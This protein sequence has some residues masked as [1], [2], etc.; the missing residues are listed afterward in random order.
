MSRSLFLALL[1]CCAL[2]AQG[3]NALVSEVKFPWTVVR[4]NLLKM[5]EKMPAE[6]YSFK[7]TP[8]IES[9]G[10]RLAHI[11]GANLFV[12][13]GVTGTPNNPLSPG[14]EFQA[15]ADRVAEAGIHRLRFG[16][17]FA[18][19]CGGDGEDQ[20]PSRRT[21]SSR[22]DPNETC[23]PEQHGPT[24]ERGVRIHV[25]LSAI[26]RHRAAIERAGIGSPWIPK[27]RNR[28]PRRDRGQL[29]VHRG[30][31]AEPDIRLGVISTSRFRPTSEWPIRSH[32]HFHTNIACAKGCY[33]Q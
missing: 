15:G 26:E 32:G 28:F 13:Q 19:R 30:K 31:A 12:C 27:E 6:N 24:L 20:L 23:N 9:F 29:P 22:V 2:F 11:A 10:Q 18:L 5:A 33:G 8:A 21:F 16:F 4:D 25:R 3:S 14:G 17:R 7:P 1:G